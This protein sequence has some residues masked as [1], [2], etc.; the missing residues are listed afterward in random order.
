M[1]LVAGTSC[2]CEDPAS[3]AWK[4]LAFGFYRREAVGAGSRQPV[5]SGLDKQVH[6]EGGLVARGNPS[7]PAVP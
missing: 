4:K 3:Q 1:P 5:G 6:P 7:D 2:M